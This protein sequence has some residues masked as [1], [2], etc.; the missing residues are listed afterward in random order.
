MQLTL[1]TL[2]N[3]INSEDTR[4]SEEE[5]SD[6]FNTITSHVERGEYE[7]A[8]PLI[9]EAFAQNIFDIRL[10]MYY[11][12]L[13]IHYGGIKNFQEQLPFLNDLITT[14]WEKLS[15]LPK[16]EKHAQQSLRWYFS[17]LIKT[18]EKINHSYNNKDLKPLEDMT[19]GIT[20]EVVSAIKQDAITLNETLSEKW[21]NK[22]IA[23]NLMNAQKWAL[24][25]SQIYL[26]LN[27]PKKQ[28]KKPGSPAETKPVDK[29]SKGAS[30]SSQ[31]EKS[32]EKTPE[33]PEI[34]PYSIPLKALEPSQEM[35][36][37]YQKLQAF[38][39]LIERNDYKK[40]VIIS[41]DIDRIL[42]SCDL[43]IYFPKLFITFF[44]LYAKHS[45]K[46]AEA[47]VEINPLLQKL[48]FSDLDAFI[49]W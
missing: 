25:L 34:Y 13:H 37:L 18:F 3:A 39:L 2:Q 22:S 19:K 36:Q 20:E 10:S 8:I 35:V 6:N 11:M 15:P 16:R 48:Y 1:E 4:T 27:P 17:R 23:N 38:Q 42:G 21:D 32:K 7:E 49:L 46:I 28:P 30:L 45:K 41:D 40:A 31:E 43:S 24:D 33:Q 44:S 5:F 29:A 9:K 12:Y 14:H 47:Q 26:S